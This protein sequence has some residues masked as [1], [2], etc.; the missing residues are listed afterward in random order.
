MDKIKLLI[1]D[2]I[3]DIRDYF[4]MILSNEPDIKVVGTASSGIEAIQKAKDLK[5]DVILMDVQMETRTAG[6]DATETIA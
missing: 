4:H 2:D 1:V 5:P 3:A 6:I